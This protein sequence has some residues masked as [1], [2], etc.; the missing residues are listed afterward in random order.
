MRIN[1]LL[2][3]SISLRRHWLRVISHFL[4]RP[5]QLANEHFSDERNEEIGKYPAKRKGLQILL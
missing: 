4:G 2:A 1:K 5:S 3:I